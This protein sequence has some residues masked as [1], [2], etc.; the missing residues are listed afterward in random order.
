MASFSIQKDI[1]VEMTVKIETSMKKY[2]KNGG[3][4]K[5]ITNVCGALGIDRSHFEIVGKRSGSVILDLRV[6]SGG[7]MTADE[8]RNKLRSA[9]TKENIGFA[10]SDITQSHKI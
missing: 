1:I 8:L 5:F 6:K 4:K 3:D 2:Q 10:A 9:I 7:S